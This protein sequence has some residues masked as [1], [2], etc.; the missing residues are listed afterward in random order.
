MNKAQYE[1]SK[2]LDPNW[3]PTYKQHIDAL[4]AQ[5]IELNS[6]L[7]VLEKVVAFPFR[8]FAIGETTFWTLTINSFF[9][10]SVLC[11]WRIAVDSD[12]DVLT[13][14]SFKNELVQNVHDSVAKAELTAE[15]K[16]IHFDLRLKAIATKIT[17][18][19][20]RVFA[21][22]QPSFLLVAKGKTPNQ[23]PQ[24]TLS[25]LH[26]VRDAVNDLIQLLGFDTGYLFLPV[27][28][29]PAVQHPANVDPRPDIVRLLDGLAKA[30]P[31]MH[32]PEGEP[33]VWPYRRELM[34][35]PELAVY[36]EYR[37]RFGLAEVV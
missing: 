23:V 3:Y 15:L 9:Q 1:A 11:A 8:L 34:S 28:Y 21:H 16:R 18:L 6:C 4:Y 17:E 35:A 14:R 24:I 20:H 12:G 7:F 32:M 13:L 27:D 10:A 22:F 37:R 31:I 26:K 30:S 29:D 25:D 2:I 19:R 36:N 5:A 33:V